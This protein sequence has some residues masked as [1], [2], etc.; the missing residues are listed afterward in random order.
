MN[1]KQILENCLKKEKKVIEKALKEAI[2]TRNSAPSFMESASDT[3]RARSEN[4]VVALEKKL[5]EVEKLIRAIPTEHRLKSSG[6]I[7]TWSY[8]ELTLNNK[9]IKL[10]VVPESFGGRNV[11]NIQL[12]SKS[13][14]LGNALENMREGNKIQFNNKPLKIIR[15]K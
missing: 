9:K 6:K 13:T 11:D 10:L 14:P 2:Y 15:V 1:K 12:I 7:S 8:V 5:A 3:T 4:L